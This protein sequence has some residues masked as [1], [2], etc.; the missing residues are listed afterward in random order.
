MA[1]KLVKSMKTGTDRAPVVL[2]VQY[3]N[4]MQ[5]GIVKYFTIIWL[6]QCQL[7]FDIAIWYLWFGNNVMLDWHDVGL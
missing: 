7:H 2:V 3:W 4:T 5:Y 1:E 6:Y